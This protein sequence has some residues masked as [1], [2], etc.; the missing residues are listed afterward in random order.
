MAEQKAKLLK[1]AEKPFYPM[2]GFFTAMALL[3][4]VQAVVNLGISVWNE[5]RYVGDAAAESMPSAAV[6]T[7]NIFNLAVAPVTGLIAG[8]CYRL[9][10]G[11]TQLRRLILLWTFGFLWIELCQLL[12]AVRYGVSGVM[13]QGSLYSGSLGDGSIPVFVLSVVITLLLFAFWARAEHPFYLGAAVVSAVIG[14]LSCVLLP[15]L[16]MSATELYDASFLQ[17]LLEACSTNTQYILTTAA[18]GAVAIH[19]RRASK[20]AV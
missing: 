16:P 3:F 19:L 15:A 14:V 9:Q 2:R 6:W 10:R 17:I 12:A 13:A 11:E 20:N 1:E 5:L 7:Q 18:V 4:L 8:I